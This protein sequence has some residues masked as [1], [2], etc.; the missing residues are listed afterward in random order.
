M[1]MR[2]VESEESVDEILF[3]WFLEELSFC[4]NAGRTS[5]SEIINA[6]NVFPRSHV[7]LSSV[8]IELRGVDE[9][10]GAKVILRLSSMDD[11]L[12]L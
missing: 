4:G 5:F 2:F 11:A 1:I 7:S 6:L 9:I 3:S 8:P 10:N 12:G